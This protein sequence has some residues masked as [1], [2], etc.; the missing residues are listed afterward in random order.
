MSAAEDAEGDGGR[1]EWGEGGETNVLRRTAGCPLRA[2]MS[3]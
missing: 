3:L 1:E 2:V